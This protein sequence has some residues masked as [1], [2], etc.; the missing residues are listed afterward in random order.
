MLLLLSR[1][2]HPHGVRCF[3]RDLHPFSV[4]S[5]VVDRLLSKDDAWPP[6]AAYLPTG[7]EGRKA[8]GRVPSVVCGNCLQSNSSMVQTRR[9]EHKADQK[10][11][12]NA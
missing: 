1:K 6:I 2:K 12:T 7:L 10:G 9:K 8:E 11:P 3:W 5:V 4:V